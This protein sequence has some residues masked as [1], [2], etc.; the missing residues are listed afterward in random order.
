MINLIAETND[1][2]K[3]I[4]DANGIKYVSIEGTYQERYQKSKEKIKKLIGGKKNV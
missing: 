1:K 2:L 4:L 3:K